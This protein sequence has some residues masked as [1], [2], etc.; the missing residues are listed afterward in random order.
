MGFCTAVSHLHSMSTKW[1]PNRPVWRWREPGAESL[2]G[3]SDEWALNGERY[4]GSWICEE[5]C[6]QDEDA[7]IDAPFACMLVI[8]VAANC[9]RRDLRG[10]DLC[11]DIAAVQEYV[12]ALYLT[13]HE[14][15]CLAL[16]LQALHP[17][18]PRRLGEQLLAAG[19]LFLTRDLRASARVCAELAYDTG[20]RF[21]LDDVAAAAALAIS[22]LALLEESPRS[23]RLWRGR[24]AIF[25]RRERRERDLLART[26]K[27]AGDGAT[28]S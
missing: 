12:N 14:R 24:A 23:S 1:T 5:I 10:E 18:A 8:R 27:N 11:D 6:I 21:Q 15:S 3:L 20:R 4:E 17:L 9:V 2:R 13:P 7:N 19:T 28:P 25:Q 26:E 16:A 22:R